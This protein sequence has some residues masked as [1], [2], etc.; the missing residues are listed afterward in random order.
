MGGEGCTGG[1]ICNTLTSP[2]NDVIGPTAIRPHLSAF[3]QQAKNHTRVIKPVLP[4]QNWH[5][6]S[7]LLQSHHPAPSHRDGGLSRASCSCIAPLVG[8]TSPSPE[9]CILRQVLALL[10]APLT[11]FVPAALAP[12]GTLH[13]SHRAAIIPSAPNFALRWRARLHFGVAG[14]VGAR[15]RALQR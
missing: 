5:P 9:F 14:S 10:I 13:F 12:A 6:L 8:L 7:P 3:C 2:T 1:L 4:A 15:C 11:L